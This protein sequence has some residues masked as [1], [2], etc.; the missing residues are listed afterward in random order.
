M[1]G[2][3][4]ALSL[5]ALGQLWISIIPTRN[6]KR[7]GISPERNR[8]DK[9]RMYRG[10]LHVPQNIILEVHLLLSIFKVYW[11]NSLCRTALIPKSYHSWSKSLCPA[12]GVSLFYRLGPMWH[13]SPSYCDCYFL[14]RRWLSI[15]RQILHF[16]S[17]LSVAQK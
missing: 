7:T 11:K 17:L 13:V 3:G 9:R 2:Q 8:K 10:I 4:D 12:I 16:K 6:W 15:K 1:N 14:D 5:Q